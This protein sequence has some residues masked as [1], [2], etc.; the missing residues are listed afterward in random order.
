MNVGHPRKGTTLGWQLYAAEESLKGLMDESQLLTTP[1]QL[2]NLSFF[3]GDL[4]GPLPCP[5]HTAIKWEK[6]NPNP[7]ST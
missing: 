3:E 6:E 5:P 4:D 2:D 7:D 1:Q